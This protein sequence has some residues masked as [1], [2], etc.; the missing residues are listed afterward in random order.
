MTEAFKVLTQQVDKT[1]SSTDFSYV[2]T[3]KLRKKHGEFLLVLHNN[4]FTH[5]NYIIEIKI[6]NLCTS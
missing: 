5:F 2:R 4:Y 1:E 3:V 6:M